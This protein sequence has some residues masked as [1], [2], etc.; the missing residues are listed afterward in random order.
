MQV[1]LLASPVIASFD[2]TLVPPVTPRRVE[3]TSILL[4]FRRSADDDWVDLGRLVKK[5]KTAEVTV[6]DIDRR[7]VS[8]TMRLDASLKAVDDEFVVEAIEAELPELEELET[9]AGKHGRLAVAHA[10]GQI[11]LWLRGYCAMPH[12]LGIPGLIRSISEKII[13]ARRGLAG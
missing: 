11:N 7:L 13:F 8:W 3:A 12:R 10:L 1:L 6:E 5:G 9:L 2:W 4:S